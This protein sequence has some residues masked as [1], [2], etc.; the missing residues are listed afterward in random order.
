MYYFSQICVNVFLWPECEHDMEGGNGGACALCSPH[1]LILSCVMSTYFP[2]L[3][4]H[5][6]H[7]NWRPG[8]MP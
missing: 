6:A 5:R 3:L 1:V 7:L 8:R 2:P 4:L